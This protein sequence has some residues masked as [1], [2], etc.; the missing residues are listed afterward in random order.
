[1]NQ[2]FNIDIDVSISIEVL[3]LP[4]SIRY[5]YRYW[6]SST[7]DNGIDNRTI[8]ICNG[9]LSICVPWSV[10][11]V[12]DGVYMILWPGDCI[13]VGVLQ[14]GEKGKYSAN[15]FALAVGPHCGHSVAPISAY[16]RIVPPKGSGD[17]RNSDRG[18]DS[19]YY[20]PGYP[21]NGER[22]VFI[23]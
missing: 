11:I 20:K 13:K 19:G 23:L 10:S 6:Y 3:I 1:M 5:W 12:N 9:L 8:E 17:N 14:R 15:M 4:R 7:S 18:D 16:P 2:C 22:T 21:A